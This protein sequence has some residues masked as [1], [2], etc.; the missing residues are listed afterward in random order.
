MR[1]HYKGTCARTGKRKYDNSLDV[2][3]DHARNPRTIRAYE[4]EFCK[5]WHATSKPLREKEQAA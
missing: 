1:R 2:L 3:L 4:C 5:G